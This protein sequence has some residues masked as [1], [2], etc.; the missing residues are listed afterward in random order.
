M[1][2]FLSNLNL[3]SFVGFLLNIKKSK[4]YKTHRKYFCFFYYCLNL[5]N[6]SFKC[7]ECKQPRD[8]KKGSKS[9]KFKLKILQQKK[10]SIKKYHQN[11]GLSYVMAEKC[12]K[13]KRKKVKGK[14]NFIK[15]IPSQSLVIFIKPLNFQ[16]L[17][18]SC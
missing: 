10:Q 16:T 14:Y 9:Q 7:C 3:N 4:S 11:F 15:K 1:F 8:V 2:F 17:F 13:R 18:N 12:V 6:N 5:S